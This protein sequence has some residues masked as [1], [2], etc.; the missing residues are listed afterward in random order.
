MKE[1]IVVKKMLSSLI[2]VVIAASGAVPVMAKDT[3][4]LQQILEEVKARIP[5]TDE[6]ENFSSETQEEDGDIRYSFNWT[7]EKD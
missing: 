2:A 6:Y 4:K 7:T 1:G 5:D 3:T